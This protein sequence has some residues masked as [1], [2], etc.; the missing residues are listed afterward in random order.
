[1]APLIQCEIFE[2]ALS[3]SIKSC[4]HWQIG[5]PEQQLPVQFD[6]PSA[7]MAAMQSPKPDDPEAQHATAGLLRLF[8]WVLPVLVEICPA[9]CLAS[10]LPV[11][12]ANLAHIGSAPF[13]DR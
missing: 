4:H 6:E 12:A 5:R 3:G 13:L 8:V 1:M 10:H 9:T 7:T 11:M 2:G